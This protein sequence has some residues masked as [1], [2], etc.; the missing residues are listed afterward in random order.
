MHCFD[1]P[2]T[3]TQFSISYRYNRTLQELFHGNI[4]NSSRQTVLQEKFS[5]GHLLANVVLDFLVLVVVSQFI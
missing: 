5:L 4:R 3:A 2:K 1:L